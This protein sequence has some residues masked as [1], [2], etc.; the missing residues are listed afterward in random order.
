M[1]G[2][3]F[4]DWSR[5]KKSLGLILAGQRLGLDC[6]T[7]RKMGL[8]KQRGCLTGCPSVSPWVVDGVETN[9]CPL[10]YMGVAESHALTL[11]IGWRKGFLAEQGGLQDQSATYVEA[12]EFLDG[13]Q[14]EWEQEEMKRSQRKAKR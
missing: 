2:R 8:E 5:R 10:S 1:G 13:N 3:G 14:A 7:C 4:S 6:Q 12:M 11:W 9:R